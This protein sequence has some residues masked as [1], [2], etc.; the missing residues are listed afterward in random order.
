MS[1][2]LRS[3][4]RWLEWRFSFH[5]GPGVRYRHPLRARLYGRL[6]DVVRDLRAGGD[7]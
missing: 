3:L 6:L 4:E 7:L 5:R 2:A 1:A